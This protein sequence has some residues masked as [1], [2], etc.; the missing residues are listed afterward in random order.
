MLKYIL[1][2]L[3]GSTIVLNAQDSLV[4]K[5]SGKSDDN[6]LMLYKVKGGQQEYVANAKS[7]TNNFKF[8]FPTK[9]A[10]GI[11]R[12]FFDIQN[13]GFIE[14]LY[15]NES[16]S[17]TFD[18]L[19]IDTSA[20]FLVSK[21][22]QIYEAYIQLSLRRQSTID[23]LQMVYFSTEKRE[24]IKV[25]YAKVVI[26]L[27][28][29]QHS[30][31]EMS[32]GLMAHEFITSNR[33]YN[34]DEIWTTPD[35]Y[36]E[37][38][39]SHFFDALDFGNPILRNS[40]RILDKVVEYVFYL[41]KSEDMEV[42]LASKQQAVNDVMLK[43]GNIYDVKREIL[44]SLLYALADQQEIEMVDFI[45]T[46]HYGKLPKEL[47]SEQFL[48]E[49]DRIISTAIGR[50]APEISWDENGEEK[51]LS[52]MKGLN[53]VII[54]VFWS[55]SCS[56]CLNDIPTLYDFTKD[57]DGLQIVAIALEEE[58]EDFD[59]LTK[60]MPQWIH[61]YGANKWTNK[62]AKNYDVNGTPSYFVLDKDLKIIAKPEVLED[63][64]ALFDQN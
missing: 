19:N 1:F 62:I 3:L 25:K 18:P 21:E 35:L 12:L 40:S 41:N 45:I 9:S 50:E 44:S 32:K 38:T 27:K 42:Y 15:N 26:E 10:P 52:D 4:V 36:L 29:I 6:Q 31:E 13:N 61:V 47:Q 28:Q 59:K 11:Y 33:N 56:H 7:D 51:K 48:T 39:Q 53:E 60:E 57:Y 58:R 64:Q 43:V 55:T 63:L 34:A 5:L 23:S 49:I 54:I 30:F 24:L 46:Q 8:Q 16:I 22:N 14:L 37:S 17:V 20:K 2:L